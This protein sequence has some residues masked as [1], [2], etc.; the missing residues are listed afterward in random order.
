MLSTLHSFIHPSLLQVLI[1]HFLVPGAKLGAGNITMIK[2]DK[3]G[4]A[5]LNRVDR[6]AKARMRWEVWLRATETNEVREAELRHLS[7][8]LQA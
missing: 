2:R 6:Q 1:V 3:S 5:I 4:G 8:A 7:R